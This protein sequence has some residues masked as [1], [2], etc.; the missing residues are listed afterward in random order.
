MYTARVKT[1]VVPVRKEPQDSSEQVTQFLYGEL[2]TVIEE[3]KQWRKCVSIFDEYAGWLDEKMIIKVEN[4]HEERQILSS[5]AAEWI[6]FNG[7]RKL[8]PAGA[9]LTHQEGAHISKVIRTPFEHALLFEGAPYLW[10]GKTIFGIDCSGLTQVAFAMAEMKLP[11]DAN[12]QA[13]LGNT[14]SFVDEAKDNDLA[15]FDNDEGKIIHVGIVRRKG[16]DLEIIH[17]NGEVRIDKL[18]HQ[19]IFKED[20]GV[21]SH[22]LRIIKRISSDKL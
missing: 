9:Q 13:E 5:S 15:F 19:G 12:Q 4:G 2:I 20:R 3:K 1:P 7:H 18:D 17:A 14:I 16:K 11:R 22:Q 6:D 8:I 21:Y 10:G